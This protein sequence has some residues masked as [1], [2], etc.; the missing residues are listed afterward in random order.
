[1]KLYFVEVLSRDWLMCITLVNYLKK[2]I[3]KFGICM[4]QVLVFQVSECQLSQ[5]F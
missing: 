3:V 2:N 5:I 1:M 4:R